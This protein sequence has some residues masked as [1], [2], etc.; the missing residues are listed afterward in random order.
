MTAIVRAAGRRA[1]NLLLVTGA[2]IIDAFALHLPGLISDYALFAALVS[3][4]TVAVGVFA[5]LVL[6]TVASLC[7]LGGSPAAEGGSSPVDA[8][9]GLLALPGT[10][11][12]VQ[13]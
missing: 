12:E 5:G 1:F 10:S 11:G 2:L 7:L 3:I 13:R 6:W 9:G 4:L 8:A